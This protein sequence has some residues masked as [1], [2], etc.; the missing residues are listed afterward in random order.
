[1]GAVTNMRP[2]LFRG[3]IAEVPFID[4]ITDMLDPSLPLVVIEYEEWGNPQDKMYFDYIRSY[5]PYDNIVEKSYP[6]LLITAGLND[7]RVMYWE[8]AKM[9][10]KLRQ[11]KKDNNLLI[12]KTNMSTGHFGK[13]GRFD[14]LKDLDLIYA[15]MLDIIGE[16]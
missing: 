12:L 7:P 11:L 14:Y 10:A 15:F 3:V 6:N 16:I 13:S 4:V 8:P 1:M 9:T 5:S 2:D